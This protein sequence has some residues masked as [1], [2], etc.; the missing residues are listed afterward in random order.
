MGSDADI[1]VL[2]PNKG[3][4][5]SADTQASSIDYNVFEGIEVSVT[6]RFMLSRG[7]VVV[8]DGEFKGQMGH[9][10]FVKRTPN[11]PVTAALSSWKA[12]TAPRKVER[13]GIPASGV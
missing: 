11:M 7:R 3:K 5:I 13:T 9:G 2:D 8:E 10:Q 4:T 12:L 1:L 6:P